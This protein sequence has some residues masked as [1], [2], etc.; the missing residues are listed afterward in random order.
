MCSPYLAARPC[1]LTCMDPQPSRYLVTAM[2][3]TH[4][5]TTSTI[6][7]HCMR[8]IGSISQPTSHRLKFDHALETV[9]RWPGRD[10]LGTTESVC[11]ER[12]GSR[13]GSAPVV[14]LDDVGQ[15]VHRP[16][17]AGAA[18][19]GLQLV[20]IEALERLKGKNIV[21]ALPAGA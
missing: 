6:I 19:H 12:A 1:L 18:Q 10:C 3:D 2:A 13:K 7:Q 20:L 17:L 16:V 14:K 5:P 4:M 8:L 11:H 9:R 15:L 21:E